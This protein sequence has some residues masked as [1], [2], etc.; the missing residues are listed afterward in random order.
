LI[1]N[2]TCGMKPNRKG[3]VEPTTDPLSQLNS[4]NATQNHKLGLEISYLV[5]FTN[6]GLADFALRRDFK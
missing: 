4:Q 6:V 5:K 2:V 3:Y 1:P